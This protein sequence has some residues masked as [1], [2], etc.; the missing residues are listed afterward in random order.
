M[1]LFDSPLFH[2][3]VNLYIHILQIV[4]VHVVMGISGARIFFKTG[5]RTR[6][7]T[8]GL[9]MGAK[10]MIVIGY[11]L[12]TEHT[13]RFR[14]WRSLLANAIL[15]S[16]EVVFWAAVAFLGIQTNTQ[17][18]S[19]IG[20]TLSWIVVITSCVLSAVATW[21]ATISILDHRYFKKNGVERYPRPAR[22]EAYKME[23]GQSSHGLRESR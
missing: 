13:V 6:A 10:S 22:G 8:M 19:G 18:C 16:L 5:P 20:C 4:L 15:N 2:S 9:A 3:R 11:Q 1:S 12:M 17:S 7:T 21:S 14:K 23:S